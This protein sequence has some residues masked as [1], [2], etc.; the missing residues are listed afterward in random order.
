MGSPEMSSQCNEAQALMDNIVNQLYMLIM[1][2]C[3][4]YLNVNKYSETELE[5][6]EV[7]RDDKSYTRNL[8]L[9]S[10]KSCQN[11]YYFCN[12]AS[13]LLIL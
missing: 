2:P 10:Q 7:T 3:K 6:I 9:T 4:D 12:D 8:K 11:Y 1:E 5:Q 13:E